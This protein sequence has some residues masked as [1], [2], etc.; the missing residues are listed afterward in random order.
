MARHPP[1]P[2]LWAPTLGVFQA[3]TPASGAVTPRPGPA[4][5]PLALERKAAVDEPSALAPRRLL[6][7][8]FRGA[9]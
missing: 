5:S 1:M 7:G 4:A 9:S 2:Q 6:Q 8:Q 3:S